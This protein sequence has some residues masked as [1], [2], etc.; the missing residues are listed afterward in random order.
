MQKRKENN[1]LYICAPFLKIY[2]CASVR[3]REFFITYVNVNIFA[4]L[5][6]RS[7]YRC[8][9]T[10]QRNYS[11]CQIILYNLSILSCGE[12]G[13]KWFIFMLSLK[14]FRFNQAQHLSGVLEYLCKIVRFIEDLHADVNMYSFANNSSDKIKYI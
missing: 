2:V 12:W 10:F 9:C 11:V 5:L 13:V 6:S 7:K 3:L 8:S 14:M 1:G 4:R